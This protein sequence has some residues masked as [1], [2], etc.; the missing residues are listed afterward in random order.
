MELS[1]SE[2]ATRVISQDAMLDFEGFERD[3]VI[4]VRQAITPVEVD[5]LRSEVDDV[6]AEGTA[7]I[8]DHTERNKSASGRFVSA[9][10]MWPERPR[11][12]DVASNSQL[13]ELVA[14]LM[15]ADKVNLYFDQSFV[16]EPGTVDPTPWHNDQPFWP[17][18]GRQVVTVWVALDK[19]TRDSGAV[20]FVAGSNAWDRWFQ[21]RSFSGENELSHN[22]EFEDVPDIEGNR[23]DYNIISWDMEPGDVLVFSGMTLHGAH[24]NASS[25]RRRRGYALRYTGSDVVYDP[26]AATTSRLLSDDIAS[27]AAIDSDSFPVVWRKN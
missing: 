20:E 5:I 9:F 16:K 12:A 27:G 6:L 18:K 25:E 11:L 10:N 4:C 24:G 8:K 17:I 19:V 22:D 2:N 23:G 14:T 21:P 26:R 13:P 1:G 15:R 3:G 7:S